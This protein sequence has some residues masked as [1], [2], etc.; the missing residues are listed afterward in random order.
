MS[1]VGTL[2]RGLAVALALAAGAH[3]ERATAQGTSGAPCEIATRERVVAVGDVH[4][5]H[6]A[7]LAILRDAQLTDRRD[8]WIGGR[9][10]LV[11]TGDVLDRGADSRKALDLLRRLEREAAQAGGQV[12]TLVGNH[13]L[14]R[15]IGDWRYV[16][17]G[18]YTAFRTAT[19]TE[20]R[21]RAW[22]I[23][24]QQARERAGAENLPFDEP[25][26]RGQFFE[27]VPLGMLELNQAF[28]PAGEYGR[29]IR[30]RPAMVRINGI[31]YVHGGVS[32]ETAPLGCAGMNAAVA[33]DLTAATPMSAEAGAALFS[34]QAS[35]PLWYRG[36]AEEPEVDFAPQLDQILTTLPATAVVIGH[37]VTPD[38]RITAR[39]GGRVIQ[40]DTGMLGGD[41]YRGGRASALEVRGGT[42]TAI[43]R[44]GVRE[45]I[46]AP[47]IERAAVGRERLPAR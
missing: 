19:S 14:M 42:V 39:F 20:L 35:G 47:A 29:W 2:A 3:T 8:R 36:L 28:S 23:V 32:A 43:Y 10:V 31:A 9:A 15:L 25:V 45:R 46:A 44:G 41:F 37:T 1:V 24:Q 17:A 26:A 33:K 5:G 11:Q 4:G 38:F 34:S 13:E 16:S 21:D 27:R 30:S 18:E 12:H 22:T 40:V 6:E 7:L